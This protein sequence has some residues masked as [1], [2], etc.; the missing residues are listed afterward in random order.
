MAGEN[1]FDVT[2]HLFVDMDDG[3]RMPGAPSRHDIAA[4][5]LQGYPISVRRLVRTICTSREQQ[6]PTQALSFYSSIVSLDSCSMRGQLGPHLFSTAGTLQRIAVH[7]PQPV[8]RLAGLGALRHLRFLELVCQEH[9]AALDGGPLIQHLSS[10]S[11]L[12]HLRVDCPDVHVSRHVSSLS[13]LTCLHL[14]TVGLAPHRVFEHLT[15]LHS[16]T[17]AAPDMWQLPPTITRFTS[18]THLTLHAH[19]DLQGIGRESLAVLA[20]P[21]LSMNMPTR[22][23]HANQWQPHTVTLSA[24]PAIDLA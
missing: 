10:L 7:Y 22:T 23:V 13:M 17:L 20:A 24:E 3:P 21:P 15:G 2:L 14:C 16:L 6:V 11:R 12:I 18:L 5:A 1:G 8:H 19:P 4:L 9:P